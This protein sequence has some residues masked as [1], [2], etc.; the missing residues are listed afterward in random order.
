MPLYEYYCSDCQGRFEVLTSYEAA[1][2]G[3]TVC[4][5]CHGANVR[6]LLSVVAKRSHGG[7]SD[8]FSDL[9]DSG[10]AADYGDSCD[11]DGGCCGGACGGDN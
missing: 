11:M 2:S 3:R 5:T 10:G 1:Q 6:R 7:A 8:D 9:S 4:A